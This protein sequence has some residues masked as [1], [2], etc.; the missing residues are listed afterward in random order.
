MGHVGQRPLRCDQR[1]LPEDWYRFSGA[2]GDRM[3]TSCV[4]KN[5][6][7]TH[8][9]GW[10]NGSHPSVADGIV[11]RRVCYHWSNNCCLWKNDI[12]VKNCYGSFFVYYL[13]RTPV[14]YL[15]Y[16]GNNGGEC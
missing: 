7:G 3:P 16:C 10:L 4:P 11:T 13:K 15:R 8:A 2:A 5:R 6:C 14:C 12:R 1:D 9:P